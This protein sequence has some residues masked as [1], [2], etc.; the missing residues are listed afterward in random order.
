MSLQAQAA[1]GLKWQA[2]EIG[3]RQVL[4]LVV[5][6]TLARLLDPAAF[7]LVGLV[8]VYIAFVGMFV[9][10]GIGTALIQRK[11]LETGHIDAAFWFNVFC[12]VLIF[13]GSVVLA[14]PI[15]RFFTE[16]K[17]EALL[18]W[19]SLSLVINAA[20]MVQHTL[21]MREMDFRRPAIRALVG[22]V[23][24]GA[25]GVV[26]AINGC[27]VWSLI[28]QQLAGSV[29]GALFLWQASTWRPRLAFSWRCLR[30]LLAVSSSVFGTS[31]L[32]FFTS[33][34][35]QVIIGRVFGP[36]LLGDYV[37]ASR[38]PDLAK[39]AI[40]Q[41][42]AAVSMP[43][44]AQMQNDYPRMRRAICK[45]MEFNAILSFAVFGGLAAIAP[46]L[47]PFVF[48]PKWVNSV[49]F[50]QLWSLHALL[51]GLFVY[52]YPVLM[53]SG[54]PGR[55]LVVGI[56]AATGA[57]LACIVGSHFGASAI[58]LGLI[59]NITISGGLSLW[60][61]RNRIGLQ[62]GSYL[63]PTAV[64]CVAAG[65]M[66]LAVT[67]TR[68]SLW[69]ACPAWTSLL[70]QVSVGAGTYLIVAVLLSPKRLWELFEI[71]RGAVRP[72]PRTVA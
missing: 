11:D 10:Q 39:T 38:I 27:G 71:V 64:P 26:M 2:I 4:S 18:Q 17:L 50:L 58:L 3:G 47:V 56:I 49:G 24:G 33:R 55:F 54:G 19:G 53:A 22:N 13:G 5:F 66:F 52:T 36:S 9:D 62:V 12:A 8:G 32:W 23:V 21:S 25:V 60:F 28:G 29:G 45:G 67:A 43:A 41:P 68:T 72:L 48:G 6:T 46:T 69:D 65:L 7:G 57:A 16:P 40:Q 37:I 35:D 31:L 63:Y 15:S 20:A 42:L 14:G 70:I 61:I 51:L 44:F 59:V 30:E 34:L 1:R